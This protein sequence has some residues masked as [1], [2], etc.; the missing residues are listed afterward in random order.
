MA[1]VKE[2][3]TEDAAASAG[4]AYTLS[5]GDEFEGALTTVSDEDWVAVELVAGKSYDIRLAGAGAEAVTDTMLKVFN[6][7]GQEVASN[8]DIEW[9]A[10]ELFSMLTFTPDESGTY[11]LSAGAAPVSDLDNAGAYTLT[12]SDGE[13]NNTDTPHT[14]QVGGV[15]RGALDDKSDEDWI[16]VDL[17]QGKT[18]D[19]TLSGIGAD[20]DTDTI[21]IIYNAAGERLARND[22]V[23]YEGGRI[24]S[25]LTFTPDATATY[26]ISTGAYTSSPAQDNAGRYQV[27]VY[28]TGVEYAQTLTGTESSE[29][30][31]TR[32]TGSIGDDALDGKGGWDWLEGGG[33]ADRIQGGDG[34]DTVSYQYSPEGVE[35]RL[36]DG[37]AR[38]GDA[39]GDTFPGTQTLEKAL[40]GGRAQEAEA[41]TAGEP[42]S[43]SSPGDDAGSVSS[44]SSGDDDSGQPVSSSSSGD[45]AS[46]QPVSSSGAGDPVSTSSSS[47]GTAAASPVQVPD[48]EDLFGSAYDDVLAGASGPNWLSGYYG[49][50]VLYGRE[51]DDWL[52][53][54]GGADVIHG[55]PGDDAALYIYSPEGV[56]VRLHDG[57]AK[58]GYAEGDTFPGAQ[59]VEYTNPDGGTMTLMEP[60][61]ED[62]Y[63]SF[64]DDI[65]AGNHRSNRLRG[66][67]GNDELEGRQGHDVLDGGNGRDWLEGGPG[68]DLLS[69]GPGQDT[70]SYRSSDASVE[71][72]LHSDT[73]KG[74]HAQGDMF[75]GRVAFAYK[76]ADGQ[77]QRTQLPDIEHLQGSAHDDVLAGDG[78]ANVL[79]GGD[80]ND[81]LYGGPL[82]GNDRLRGGDGND[83]L[84]GGK[85]ADVLQGGE[86][87]DLLKGGLGNDRLYGDEGNDTLA[88]GDG[89][90]TFFLTTGGGNDTILDFDAGAD[91][92]DLSAFRQVRT[93]ADLALSQRGDDLVIDLSAH[94]GGTVTLEDFDRADLTNAQVIF[95]ST[96]DASIA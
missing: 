64:H 14:V 69:G 11:Y 59:A 52:D 31:H 36:H 33:G 25:K 70:A 62:L 67:D 10:L 95:H 66:L 57:T 15:F 16:K 82:G 88:G 68:A 17:E 37:T 40:R 79:A 55:G 83:K 61:V 96:D 3:T 50:D 94:R 30:Y 45:D 87:D 41:E 12:V 49:D 19:I 76:D 23:D 20:T 86:G 8:D 71:V 34:A 28:D 77:T 42:V 38:G 84:Y 22:D 4:T 1:T 32:L 90:D 75:T 6:A 80:G 63:G 18:Y 54:G 29:Y 51:G 65:L 26:Y 56:E 72:R 93:T 78:R 91:K 35:V 60:D 43:P 39:E 58:G 85:G 9:Q 47:S 46:D 5:V 7:A 2:R 21:L 13:D 74:G 92:L 44:S 73:A 89:N 48:V 53:G 81:V 27:A 24:D